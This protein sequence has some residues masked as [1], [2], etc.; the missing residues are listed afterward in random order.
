VAAEVDSF[1]RR[2][3]RLDLVP[4][5]KDVGVS[6][7]LLREAELE[8]HSAWLAGLEAA[9]RARIESLTRALV[10]KLLHRILSGLRGTA[11]AEPDPV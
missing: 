9:E 10:N 7:E 6:I 2:M 11:C 5:I 4:A 3:D 1:M 8:R